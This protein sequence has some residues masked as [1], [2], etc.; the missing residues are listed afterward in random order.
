[1]EHLLSS[2]AV[3][4]PL[5][6]MMGIGK[7]ATRGGILPP[8]LVKGI[9][10]LLYY[11]FLPATVFR[12]VYSVDFSK[13]IDF[14]L[15]V[16]TA[17]CILTITT[18]AIKLVPR[19]LKEPGRAGSVAQAIF[20]GNFIL[21]G[22]VICEGIY[23]EQALPLMALL[24]AFVNPF[25]NAMGTTCFSL[26]RSKKTAREKIAKDILTTPTI[27]ATFVALTLT[28]TGVKVSVLVQDVIKS[29]A[30]ATTPVAL[31][32]LGSTI[33]VGNFVKYKKEIVWVTLLKMLLIPGVVIVIAI[34]LG[35]RNEALVA[36][37]SVI[38]V[39]VAT[40]SFPVASAMG[41]DADLA[42]QLMVS[43]SVTSILSI[44]IIVYLLK[45]FAFI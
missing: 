12:Q 25:C 39:P 32:A 24:V 41:G 33:T 28:V 1:M 29:V 11:I 8:E 23:G 27:I 19:F 9:N 40:S 18:L 30:Q 22:T 6:V 20:R 13:G 43:S 16:Y 37:V 36:I 3:V 38:S 34:L 2:A 44:F 26:L 14:G 21:F 35:F 4:F 7:I 15:V 31:I 42:A 45:T 10:R 5:L 17:A